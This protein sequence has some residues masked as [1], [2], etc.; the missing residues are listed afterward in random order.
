MGVKQIWDGK[1]LPPIDSQVLIKLAS[2]GDKLLA[3]TVTGY[4]VRKS[5]IEDERR[6]GLFCVIIKVKY[7]NANN[8][9]F[10]DECYPLDYREE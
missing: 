5:V 10:L 4:E 1:N 3:Y 9:C 7:G 8:E 2:T 6:L